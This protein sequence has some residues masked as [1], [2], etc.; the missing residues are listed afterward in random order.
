LLMLDNFASH[1][2]I[3][4]LQVRQLLWHFVDILEAIKIFQNITLHEF[5]FGVITAEN[6]VFAELLMP[7]F[8][9]SLKI[10]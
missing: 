9:V 4:S 8:Q 1:L 5:G 6:P 3:S 2:L 10:H 7:I